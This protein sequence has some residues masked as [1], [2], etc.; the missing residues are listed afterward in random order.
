MINIEQLAWNLINAI[1]E[2]DK[3]LGCGD[4]CVEENAAIAL[5]KDG[6]KNLPTYATCYTPLSGKGQKWNLA[7]YKDDV[8]CISVVFSDGQCIAE[9]SDY[10]GFIVTH[11][12]KLTPWIKVDSVNTK[13]EIK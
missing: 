2:S 8:V 3:R 12:D 5:L 1:E 4:R 9:L 11:I 6:L 13:K 10:G 7:N